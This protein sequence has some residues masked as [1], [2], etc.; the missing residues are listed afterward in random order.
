MNDFG[1]TNLHEKNI[2]DNYKN[3]NK[4]FK[5]KQ[6]ESIKNENPYR[7]NKING[8]KRNEEDSTKYGEFVPSFFNWMTLDEQKERANELK[9]IT[10]NDENCK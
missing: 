7:K 3:F 4:N 2:K 5:L 10:K 1:F 9:N 6:R 8:D